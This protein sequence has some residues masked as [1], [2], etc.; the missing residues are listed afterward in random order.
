MPP[1]RARLAQAAMGTKALKRID[2]ILSRQP[3]DAQMRFMKGVML[4]NPRRRRQLP[5]SYPADPGLP[6][7]SRNRITTWRFSMP[8]RASMTRPRPRWTRRC[9]TSP[10]Y[11]TAFENLGDVHA[12]LASQAYDKALQIDPASTGATTPARVE[13]LALVRSL[14]VPAGQATALAV[15]PLPVQKPADPAPVVVTSA[16]PAAR[17]TSRWRS[18]RRSR[19][20]RSSSK[21]PAGA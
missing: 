11:A 12:R 17:S 6:P 10:A 7:S 3:A 20:G 1:N 13:K 19:P 4:S 8:R 5:V 21:R 16:K 14:A 2:A 15:A 18:S 9:R